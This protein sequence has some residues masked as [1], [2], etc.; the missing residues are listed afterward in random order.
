MRG[1][2]FLLVFSLA[3]VF[4]AFPL[5][6]VHPAEFEFNFAD[7]FPPTHIHA[8]LCD[9]F[10]KEV[11][12]RTNGRVKIAYFPGQAL[13]KSPQIYDGI[14][15]GVADMGHSVFAYTRGR[16]PVMEAVDLPLGYSKG[17]QSTCVIN[18][19]YKEV[20]PKELDEVKVLYL[21]AHPPGLIHSKKPVYKLEDLKGLKIRCTGTMA[22]PVELLGAV[23]VAMDMP[24][25][26]EALQKGV[27]DATLNPIETLK[28]WKHAELIK[29]TT[30][31]Y[32]I[33]YVAGFYV[34][35]NLKK[36][37][38]LPKDI[39]KVF[40][41]VSAEWIPK[42]GEGWDFIDDEARK[43][44]LSMGNKFIP[45]SKE[46]GAR[47]A[48]AVAPVIDEWIKDTEKKGLPGKKYITTL[49]KLLKRCAKK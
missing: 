2:K 32:S 5:S 3:L 21:H 20:K 4:V 47:W 37:N 42:H 24:L 31:C 19:F 8:K 41:E 28:G 17:K 26:Y 1:S 39:Q 27:V 36:W 25:T 22:K 34:L 13:L 18:A 49:K 30:E 43:Y 16:F 48:K 29:A 23:P 33:G 12:K 15:K 46:E 9:S 40:D 11:E 45:L 7:F 10:A 38:A 44:S 6:N 35:M 14:L